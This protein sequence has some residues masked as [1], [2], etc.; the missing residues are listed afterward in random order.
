MKKTLDIQ[1]MTGFAQGSGT[2]SDFSWV[3]EGV[4]AFVRFWK[5]LGVVKV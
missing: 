3:W 5:V 2:L 4:G 1:S